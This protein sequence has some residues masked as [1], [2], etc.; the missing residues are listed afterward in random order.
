[1]VNRLIILLVA[2]YD[3]DREVDPTVDVEYAV[4]LVLAER[5][6]SSTADAIRFFFFRLSVLLDREEECCDFEFEYCD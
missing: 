4:L 1:M 2:E 6:V 3:D 5:R